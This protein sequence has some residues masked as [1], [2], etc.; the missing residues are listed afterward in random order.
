MYLFGSLIILW[1]SIFNLL[2]KKYSH[3]ISANLVNASHAL[4]F[5][6]HK[7]LLGTNCIFNAYLT[8]SF[9]VYDFGYLVISQYVSGKWDKIPFLI[10]HILAI[11]GSYMIYTEYLAE[12]I[13]YIFYLLELSNIPL[14]VSYHNHKR[15]PLHKNLIL[16][17]DFV[18]FIWYSYYR[19]IRLY[20]YFWSIWSV[21]CSISYLLVGA[22]IL[23]SSMGTYWSYLLFNKL[24]YQLR[25]VEKPLEKEC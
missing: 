3:N 10:H 1:G 4:I 5:I 25:I 14:Y 9:Y 24:S 8:G 17:I 11:S 12:E 2:N 22:T 16:V 20:L 23:I 19:N 15:R 6:L 21:L 18:Q 7:I 13:T